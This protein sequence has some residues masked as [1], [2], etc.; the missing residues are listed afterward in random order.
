MDL[1]RRQFLLRVG[2]SGG[3]GA[4]YL[5]MQGLG[6]LPGDAAYAG[7]PALEPGSGK[8]RSVVILGA[9][10]AGMTAAYELG[11]AG[12]ACRV[13][14]ARERVGGRCWTLRGGDR[15]DEGEAGQQECRFDDGLYF[16]PGPARIP[17]QHTALLAYCRE[18]GV[19]LQ[20]F[21][22]ANRSALFQDDRVLDGAPVE[23]RQVHHDTAGHIAELLIKCTDS[24]ALD[25]ELTDIDRERLRYF[26]AHFGALDRTFSY[27]GSPRAGYRELPG[28]GAK[29]GR[30][31]E[32]IP[33]RT[34]VD[35]RFW[36][37]HMYFE[38]T[39]EQQATMLEP[40]GGMDRI[41][42]A[43]E[44]RLGD[45]ITRG[46]VVREVRKRDDGV[47]VVYRTVASGQD[48]AVDADFCVCTIPLN[49]LQR[50][51]ADFG[52]RHRAAISN[53]SYVGACKLAWQAGRRFWE[54][55]DSIYGGISWTERDVTQIWYPSHGFNSR[56][57]V[58]LGAYNFEPQ[59]SI[60]A[61]RTPQN[62]AAR[63]REAIELLHPGA[64][65][66]LSRPVSVA[67]EN[68]PYNRAAFVSWTKAARERAY[69]VLNLP[70]ERIYLAGEHMSY[71]TSWQEGAV[72]SAHK[73]AADIGEYVRTRSA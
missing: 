35:S 48:V 18:F 66:A 12:Y 9:G 31:R 52:P 23:S 57:G 68:V 45:S 64:G 44:A 2:Q 28:A 14:E 40:V 17:S 13:L 10:L 11:K 20:I 26:L 3:V 47:R 67:W 59:A 27:P 1:T 49:L 63:S 70:D 69:P 60:F 29:A 30:H 65:D 41:A 16:N 43:F 54:E 51:D 8:G 38:E 71:W 37:W 50:L 62:R 22:N 19:E 58:L 46:A 32:P 56:H 7:E 6:L 34:L 53:A 73:V 4:T 25:D 42:R 72:R 36:Y 33:L 5:V 21:V 61:R 15:V 24:G 39:F 55:R